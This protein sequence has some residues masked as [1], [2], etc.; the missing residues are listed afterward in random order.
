[1]SNSRKTGAIALDVG[2]TKIAAGVV[3]WPSGA[4]LNRTVVLTRANRGGK[5]VLEDTLALAG[6]LHAW[7]RT[8][9]IRVAGIGAGVAE[10]VDRDGNV[11]SS[12]TIAWR[13]IPVQRELS[14]IAPAQVESDV[15]TAALAEAI[16]GAGQG[17]SHFVYITVGTGISHCLVEN[18]RP[19]KG[20]RGNAIALASSPLST[21]C[22]CCGA[23]LRPVLEEF[24]SGPAIARRFG[25]RQQELIP[26][27]AGPAIESAHEV[28]L[29][30]G[31]GDE[32]AKEILASAGEA[33]G[34]SAAFLVNVLDPGLLVVGGGV[35]LAGGL[36]WDAFEKACRQH[37]F[38]D[39]SRTL[40]I[41]RAKLGVDAG[42]VGAGAIVFTQ[43]ESGERT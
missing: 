19:F 29:A 42:L 25:Q 17:Q 15:R 38:A 30:A 11:A 20:A 13:G 32:L 39:S 33:L 41:A 10:L 8:Q 14:R 22:S 16:F 5:P 35:G 23:K 21:T 7:A 26:D 18:G 9:D 31:E 27:G 40:P 37:I 43:S 36:Y 24:A 1:M 4:I 34:V 3:L 12:C 6:D 28:F 2:G